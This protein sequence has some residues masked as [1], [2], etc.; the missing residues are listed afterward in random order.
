MLKLAHH[1]V[2][3]LMNTLDYALAYKPC[4]EEMDSYGRRAPTGGKGHQG[5]MC[6]WGGALVAWESKTQP[7]ATLSTTEC[8]LLGYVDGLTLG[9]SVG[10]IVNVLEQNALAHEGCYVLRG[11]NLSG[12]QL[13]HAP[14][15]PWRTRHLRLRSNV[16]R[17]RLQMK[18]WHAEH[19]PGA[20]LCADLLT[21]AITV[22]RSWETFASTVGLASVNTEPYPEDP[23]RSR[24][25]KLALGAAVALGLC[26]CI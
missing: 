17:E 12:L 5:I 6:L 14:S 7:F 16:L 19:I 10:A 20:D 15:G 3:Y 23:A 1:V 9:E 26:I 2:G 25:K 21:K 11:D 18:L 22:P 13:L 24:M 8:E 4:S